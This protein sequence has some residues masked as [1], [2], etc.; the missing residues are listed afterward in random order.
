ERVIWSAHLKGILVFA[1]PNTFFMAAILFAIAVL[2]RNEIVSFVGALLLVT[3]YGVSEALLSD[4]E[5][6]RIA[7][8][9]DPFAVRTFSLAT[10][11]WTVAEKNAL[12]YGLSGIMLWNRL[13]WV[14]VGVLFLVFACYRFS[15]AEK[16]QKAA[17]VKK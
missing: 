6:E 4:I 8:L 16:R 13:L 5:R 10:K 15:F 11:Y 14:S 12:A 9:L 1:L 7:A 17:K 3:G 2:A